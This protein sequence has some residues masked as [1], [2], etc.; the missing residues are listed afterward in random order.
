MKIIYKVEWIKEKKKTGVEIVTLRYVTMN[1]PAT[2]P[3][4][5]GVGVSAEAST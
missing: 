4:R 5:K 1:A 2:A 3:A